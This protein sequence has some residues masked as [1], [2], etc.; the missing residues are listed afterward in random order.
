[1]SANRRRAVAVKIHCPISDVTFAALLN[2]KG[3]AIEHDP[4]TAAM[5]AVIRADNPLG[6]FKLYNSVCEISPGWESF[7]PGPD[8]KPTMGSAGERALSPTAIITTYADA[9]ADLA[10]AIDALMAA[11]PWEIPVI[12]LSEVQLLVR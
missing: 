12:E 11:H 10:P 3:D 8:A 9:N 1:M 2:G 5:L 4:A 6:D 7:Q